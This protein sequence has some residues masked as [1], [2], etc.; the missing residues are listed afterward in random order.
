MTTSF[1]A[2]AEERTRYIVSSSASGWRSTDASIKSRAVTS[3]P[4]S[5]SCNACVMVVIPAPERPISTTTPCSATSRS[6][7]SNAV[8]CAGINF[9]ED[10]SIP[11]PRCRDA[12]GFVRDGVFRHVANAIGGGARPAPAVRFAVAP[13]E[14]A[15]VV[16]VL[17]RLHPL[18]Q[19]ARG[20]IELVRVCV[21][22][23]NVDLIYELGP[24]C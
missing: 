22:D 5:L 7:L 21:S 12:F 20:P 10:T 3:S 15:L 8:C 4:P 1:F 13:H 14:E 16:R 2:S 9:D 11:P 17:R 24:E 19:L 6:M 23:E 18:L